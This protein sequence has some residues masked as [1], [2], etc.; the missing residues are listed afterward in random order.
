M[1]ACPAIIYLRLTIRLCTQRHV[2]GSWQRVA[3]F[4]S[5]LIMLFYYIHPSSICWMQKCIPSRESNQGPFKHDTL[6]LPLGQ[7]C[8]LLLEVIFTECHFWF[9]HKFVPN[10]YKIRKEGNMPV[11]LNAYLMSKHT[12]FE[13]YLRLD[14]SW[15][16]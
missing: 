8:Y 2:T 10:L 15:A 14:M 11:Y 12:T 9:E 7:G 13:V 3:S 16:H 1:H 6:P 5:V 4:S